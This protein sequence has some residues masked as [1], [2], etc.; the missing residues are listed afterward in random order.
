MN[1]IYLVRHGENTANITGEMSYKLV[2]YSLTPKGVS[3]AQQTAAFFKD[4]P[5]DAIYASPLKRAKETA[6]AIGG[7]VELPVTLMEQFREVNVGELERR[8]PSEEN[9]ELHNRIVTEWYLGRPEVSFPEGENYTTLLQRMRA[10]LLEVTRGKE[11]QHIVVVGHAGIFSFTIR[12]I[13]QNVDLET[14]VK[15]GNNN[16]SITRIEIETNGNNVTGRLIDWASCDHLSGEAAEFVPANPL[17]PV[18]E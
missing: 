3:Q 1:T 7:A 10:G 16:C 11:Q 5:I 2:D 18:Q 8:P 15:K 4:K 9:W 17:A 14:L 13:C 6:E 12:D